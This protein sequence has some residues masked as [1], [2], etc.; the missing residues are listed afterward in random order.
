M[1]AVAALI[2]CLADVVAGQGGAAMP[3]EPPELVA[4]ADVV[5]PPDA[6]REGVSG[7]VVLDV[8]LD[9]DGTILRVA[10]KEAADPRLA[11]A[12]L[13][14][15][16]NYELLPAREVFDDGE[17]RAIAIR[18]AYTLTFT[19]DEKE[20]ERVLAEDE[21]R[22]LAAE[23]ATAPVNL[24]GRVRVAAE[25]AVVSG[26]IVTVEGTDLEAITDER[27][28]F[29]FRGAPEGR[30][31]VIVDAAGFGE[32]RIVLEDVAAIVRIFNGIITHDQ[33]QVGVSI[34]LALQQASSY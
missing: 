31:V 9:D 29:E 25:P 3:T 14:A 24:A 27:G 7:A 30:V 16:T 8:D 5:Y 26:A 28:D 2:V 15:L 19:I 17:E 23:V 34:A 33:P 11:W 4:E 18:F 10:V 12:A 13:G 22:R 20:R 32:G 1:L 6:F 21:A